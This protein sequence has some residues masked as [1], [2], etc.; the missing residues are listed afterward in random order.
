ME[1]NGLT[2][3]IRWE[4]ALTGPDHAALSEL[5]VAAFPEQ[6]T[7]FAGRSWAWARKE[8]RLWLS[9]RTGRP[10]AHLAVERRLVD[11]GGTEVLVAGIGEVAVAPELH[12]NGVGAALMREFRPRLRTEFAADF[13]FVQCGE[14]VIAF[15]RNAGWTPVPNAVRHLDPDDERTVREG[16]WPALVMP[17]RRALAEWPNGLVDLRG[18]PW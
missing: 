16:V 5:L 17:G 6:P 3:T 4:T 18:L 11:V 13:G 7:V 8:A 2:P 10:V 14:Q 1:A 12:G 15:Y 9:D